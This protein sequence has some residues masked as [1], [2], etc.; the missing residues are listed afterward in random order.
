LDDLEKLTGDDQTRQL[1][2]SLYQMPTSI[3][4]SAPLLEEA[5]LFGIPDCVIHETLALSAYKD[6]RSDSDSTN[7][8]TRSTDEVFGEW[9]LIHG[10]LAQV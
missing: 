3:T 9:N 1:K 10:R 7:R 4:D 8:W 2:N 5:Q 6:G